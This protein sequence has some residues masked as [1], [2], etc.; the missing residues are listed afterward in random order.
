MDS[1]EKRISYLWVLVG[2]VFSAVLTGLLSVLL[3]LVWDFVSVFVS[4]LAFLIC[5]VLA[6]VYSVALYRSWG[7]E[8]RS[9]YLY[10]ERGVF[11]F[12]RTKVPFVRIQHV[13]SKRNIIDRLFGVSKLVVYTAGSRGADVSIPGLL[14]RDA[15]G[16]QEELRKVAAESE[17]EFGDAV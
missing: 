8:L 11:T 6:I 9:D 7:F 12:V 10:L 2:F 14:P 13:D 16:I 3:Y 5:G 15:E 1:L 17:E 4:G